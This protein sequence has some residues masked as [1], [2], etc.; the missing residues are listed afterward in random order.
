MWGAENEQR[1]DDARGIQIDSRDGDGTWSGAT[2]LQQN[3]IADADAQ[4]AGTEGQD[5]GDRTRVHSNRSASRPSAQPLH[6]ALLGSMHR[7]VDRQRETDES[8]SDIVLRCRR[9]AEHNGRKEIST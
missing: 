5:H 7:K 3:E 8:S 9:N 6:D 1:V 2:G 4:G